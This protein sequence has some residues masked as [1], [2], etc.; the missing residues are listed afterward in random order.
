MA[1][2]Q[3]YKG[4]ARK[5]RIRSNYPNRRVTVKSNRRVRIKRA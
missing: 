1:V 2:H 5:A 3:S 4:T